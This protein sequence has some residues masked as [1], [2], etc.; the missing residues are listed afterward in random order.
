MQ[1]ENC[2]MLWGKFRQLRNSGFGPEKRNERPWLIYMRRTH[3]EAVES[4][5]FQSRSDPKQWAESPAEAV[6]SYLPAPQPRRGM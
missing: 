5:D 1:T 4:P 6:A 2:S 3:S